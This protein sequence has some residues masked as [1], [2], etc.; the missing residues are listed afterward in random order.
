[1]RAVVMHQLGSPEVLRYQDWPDPKV[2][3]GEVLLEVEAATVNRTD[4]F[5]RSG[6]FFLQKDL[7]HILGMDVAG[8][9]AALGPEVDGWAVGDRVVATF[10]E[11]GR[12]REGAY[13]ELTTVPV[14]EL[15]RIPD[16]LDYAD[17]AAV[18]LAFT[19]AW[20]ALVQ[21]GGLREDDTVLIQAASSGVGTSAVQ[22]AH[23]KGAR[24]IALSSAGKAERLRELGA[25]IV[26]DRNRS[27][28]VELV[29]EATDDVGPSLVLELVGRRT[30]Q[31][32]IE[33]AAESARVVIA[34]TMSGDEAEIDA[35][36]VLIKNLTI[37]GSFGRVSATD[38]DGILA[39]FA[40]GTYRAVIDEVMPL[41]QA[42]DAHQR[43]EDGDTFGKLVLAPML[44]AEV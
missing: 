27:E 29:A 43:L 9:I 11:L 22:I 12:A 33:M 15:H 35:M 25:D 26:I 34:G 10:E 32:S 13:A 41:S 36:D 17:A 16:G 42:Y 8:R 40:G 5:L 24:V 30:L 21:R 7:P 1:M 44:D 19:T 39:G 20:V 28:V 6:R 18:G 31:S 38:F 14:E 4:V 3:P 2:E 37:L 23:A